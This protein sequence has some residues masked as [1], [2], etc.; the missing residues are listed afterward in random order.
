[1]KRLSLILLFAFAGLYIKAQTETATVLI[2]YKTLENK[3]K[4][5]NELIENP[6]KNTNPKVWLERG[7][8]FL[9]IYKV[10]LQYLRRDM[11]KNELEI[12]FGPPK[13]KQTR[14]EGQK[15]LEDYIYERI[16]ITLESNK[17]VSWEET[18]KIVE[19]PLPQADE[20]FRKTVEL[21]TDDKLTD[22][23]RDGLRN[24]KLYYESE[25]ID[26]FNS[27]DYEKAYNS[28]NSVLKI[29]ELPPMEGIID[30]LIFYNTARAAK[31]T[32]KN[33]VAI[34]LFNKSLELEYEDPFIYVFMNECY[35]ALG[36]TANALET[37]KRGFKENPENQSILIELINFYLLRGES[38][39]A[40]EYLALAKQ[41]DPE[42]ISF[43]FAEGT[44]FDKLDRTD[45]AIEA[46]KECIE[47]DSSYF[48][49]YFN[50][51]VVYYNKAVKIID[52][53]QDIE[54]LATYN[55]MMAESEVEFANAIPYMEKAREIVPDDKVKCEV[56]ST[57]KTL[58]YRVKNE[59]K[60]LATIE[61]MEA[62]GCPQ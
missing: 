50:L 20:A 47:L 48:N 62:M 53:A 27:K 18:A 45:D 2:N 12:L 21:D 31:E 13:T 10:H 15:T 43:I 54:D 51:G 58:Y 41:D 1:M 39:A 32:G 3:L 30:T 49:A 34:E 17:V 56:L 24:L 9:D 44:I 25:G 52:D 35:K 40:L 33:E 59:E 4:K 8:L 37:L 11:T 28:F 38:E 36:D 42:N 46:Y 7:E 5:S 26:A 29:N 22:K 14:T 23:V 6:K 55:E 61:E 19:N 16:T 60:R 57:L